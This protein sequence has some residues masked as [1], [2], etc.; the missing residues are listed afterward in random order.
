VNAAEHINKTVGVSIT[1]DH[2]TKLVKDL[3][4]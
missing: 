1:A 2:T 4:N 3:L